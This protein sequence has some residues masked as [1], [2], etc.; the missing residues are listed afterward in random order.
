[1]VLRGELYRADL[2]PVQGCEQG[3]LRPVLI[4]QNNMGNRY[5]PT[6]IVA[7]IT[8]RTSKARLP[9]H[10]CLT[11]GEGGLLKDSVVLLEQ[12]RT[13][14]KARLQGRLGILEEERMREVEEALLMSLGIHAIPLGA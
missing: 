13:I 10:I 6:V 3:G 1:M 7:A 4:L 5:S 11:Q 14:D 8:S 9:T 12:L 2:N